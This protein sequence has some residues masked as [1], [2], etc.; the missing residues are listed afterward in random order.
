MIKENPAVETD[1]EFQKA[2]L[3][4]IN[5]KKEISVPDNNQ[6]SND[7]DNVWN[8]NN[9][10]VK[11]FEDNISNDQKLKGKYAV[12]L[13]VT[14]IVELIVLNMIFILNGCG[15]LKYADSTFNIFITAGIAEVFVLVRVIVKYLFKDNLTEALKIII[16]SNN[17]PKYQNRNNKNKKSDK[18]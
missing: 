4:K 7:I 9:R 14:L 17:K 3:E 1:E 15:V 5:S 8:M 2:L 12:I 10:I 6:Y 16:E 11:L 13:I 18:P